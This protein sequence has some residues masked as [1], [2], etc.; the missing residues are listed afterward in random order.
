[1]KG[2]KSLKTILA[3]VLIA[4]FGV[5]I[6][7]A[8]LSSTLNVTISKVTQ[9]AESWD[10]GFDGSS[11]TATVGG[12][13]A[14]GRSC[15]TA[16]ITRSSVTVAN[17]LLSKPDDS[18]TYKLTISNAGTINAKITG[19]TPTAPSGITCNPKSGA[20]MVCGNITYK[21]AT[22]ANGSTLLAENDALNSG[23]TKDVYLIVKYTGNTVSGTSVTQSGASFS[24]VYGQV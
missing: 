21:I 6:A 17:T 22:D 7:Y 3:C 5:S 23:A 14:T 15:G 2:T 16:T 4:V 9:N 8:A 10:V 19:I 1:M 12:T 20:N 24:V 11:A 13:S 18:C